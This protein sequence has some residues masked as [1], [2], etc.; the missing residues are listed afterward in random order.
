[1]HTVLQWVSFFLNGQVHKDI[2]S[3]NLMG[4]MMMMMISIVIHIDSEMFCY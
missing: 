1:M 4:M 2:W 3:L